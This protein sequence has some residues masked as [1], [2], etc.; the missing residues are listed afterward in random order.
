MINK[1]E[2][3]IIQFWEEGDSSSPVI[4]CCC[5][6]FNHKKYIE[7][8]LDS[9][10]MQESK[11]A[12]EIIVHDDVS[13]DG[14]IEV[15]KKYEQK[16]PNIIKPIYQTQN[17]WSLG[18]RIMPIVFKAAKGEYAALCEGDDYWTDK[19]KLQIQIDEM[20]RFPKCNISFHYGT[21]RYEDGSKKEEVF[22]KYADENRF[23]D[24]N[25]II[26][27]AGPLMPTASICL[28]RKFIDYVVN[29]K[30][31]FFRK[32]ITAFFIQVLASGE[33]G[34][35]YINKNMCTYRR[36]SKGSWTEAVGRN[37]EVSL[38]WKLK[39]I[40]AV[41]QVK[42]LT[43]YQYNEKLNNLKVKYYKYI[44]HSRNIPISIRKS[45]FEQF[46]QFLNM[47][48]KM[49][50]HLVY[51]HVNLHHILAYIKKHWMR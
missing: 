15:L 34:A 8:A 3:Q 7:E 1:S 26:D 30:D 16:F 49:M 22:C 41:D 50:W 40:S 42:Q 20:R 33:G 19:N 9:M 27:Y 37:Y 43:N 44:L 28:S 38:E 10:L 18:N 36:M 51:K 14:T 24:T 46:K 29:S 17:Q 6:T 11:Y 2:E 25:K 21:K 5:I 4:S 32:D 45:Y 48:D 31:N 12:F 47:K 39:S 35:R 23:F 13:T